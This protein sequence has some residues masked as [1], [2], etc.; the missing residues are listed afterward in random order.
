MVVC[1]LYSFLLIL[2]GQLSQKEINLEKL[3]RIADTG[4]P[5]GGGLRATV[6]KVC[7][8]LSFFFFY[9][10]LFGVSSFNCWEEFSKGTVK[11]G[12]ESSVF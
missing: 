4:L 9:C 8:V 3:Q 2:C 7:K 11:D 5:E 6:W 1:E 10:F 12:V